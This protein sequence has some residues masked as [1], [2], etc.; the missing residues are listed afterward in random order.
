MKIR[1]YDNKN[2][3]QWRV[4]RTTGKGHMMH[5]NIEGLYKKV[6]GQKDCIETLRGFLNEFREF[7]ICTAGR[8]ISGCL[9]C[10]HLTTTMF[11]CWRL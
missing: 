11:F 3:G 10:L 1:C 7:C 6:E 4:I 5:P 8:R 2:S 9:S